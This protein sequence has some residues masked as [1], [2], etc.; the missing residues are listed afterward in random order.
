M[1]PVQP[2]QLAPPQ[3]MP[4][5]QQVVRMPRE[6]PIA[7]HDAQNQNITLSS[8]MP[9]ANR[10][11]IFAS[12]NINQRNILCMIDTGSPINLISRT[13]LH[14]LPFK[15]TIEPSDIVAH[16]ANA[17]PMSLSGKVKLEFNINDTIHYLNFYIV[18]EVTTGVLLG[19]NWLI[20]T[21][22]VLDLK[23]KVL[24]GAHG[25]KIPLELRYFENSHVRKVSLPEDV[26]IPPH[27]ELI[28]PGT[29]QTPLPTEGLL[30]PEN[31]VEERGLLMARVI[32]SP[33]ASHVPVQIINPGSTPVKLYK[34]TNVG[35]LHEIEPDYVDCPV[36]MTIPDNELPNN[37]VN[38]GELLPEQSQK[39]ER[40]LNQYSDLFSNGA[41]DLGKTDIVEHK[42]ETG[43]SLPIKQLP[44]RLPIS[45]R[46]VVDNQIKDMLEAGVITESDSPWSSPIVLAKKKSGDWRFCVDFRRLN[47]VT[48]KDAYSLP[49]IEDMMDD[50][51]GQQYFS[52]L[53]LASGYWQV[54]VE[55]QSKPKTAFSIPSG[56]HYQFESMPF[57]L[58]NAV[59]T[60]QRLMSQLLKGDIG[61]R[62]R[63]YINDILIYGKDF[64]EHLKA[65]EEVFKIFKQ[66]GLKLKGEKCFIAA[67]SVNYLGFVISKNGIEVDPAKVQAI[68]TLPPP[69]NVHELRRFIGMIGYDRKHIPNASALLTPLNK[70]LQKDIKWQWT[71]DCQISFDR[72]K[73]TLTL[74][75]IL[76]YPDFNRDFIVYCDASD[77]GIGA[78]LQQIQDD[79]TEKV[80]AYA[81]KCFSR[82]ESNWSNTEKEA[83]AVVWSLDHFHP[84]IYGRKVTVHTDHKALQ[85][86]RK[87]KSPTGKLAR[88][89]L[90]LEEYDYDVI[91]RP[92]SLMQ[93]VDT[94]SRQPTVNSIH[95]TS[96]WSIEELQI[97]QAEDPVVSQVRPWLLMG[98]KPAQVPTND[99]NGLRTLYNIFDR[100]E[101][102][103][104]LIC[105]EWIDDTGVNKYQV[106][107]PV[108]L[109][110]EI[111]ER[112]HID[113][114][115]LGVKKTFSRIQEEFYW[116]CF[117]RQ[118]EIFC[119]SCVTC[120]KNK[121]I[122]NP[123]WAM[124]PIEVV[125][126]PFYMVGMDVIG[127]LKT[128]P[129]GNRYILNIVDYFTK[130]VEAYAI[131]DQKS[132]TVSRCIEDLC[133]R[134][135]VPSIIL[136]DKGS[137]FTSHLFNGVCAQFGI[138]HRTT[139][140]YH[141]Q[142]DRLTERSN[143]TL[144][145]L[146]RMSA[147]KDQNNWDINL[148]SALQAIRITKHASTGISPFQLLY[149]RPPRLPSSVEKQ[150][151]FQDWSYAD[152]ALYLR[153]LRNRLSNLKQVALPSIEQC[154]RKQKKEYDARNR[155]S[156]AQSFE[157]GDFVLL[158]N[159]RARGFDAKFTGP[160]QVIKRFESDYRIRSQNTGK[161]TVVHFNRLKAC[162]LIEKPPFEQQN[163]E[164]SSSEDDSDVREFTFVQPQ[165][166]NEQCDR[167][168]LELPLQR[169]QRQRRAPDYYGNPVPLD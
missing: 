89:I 64:E 66:A 131:P 62:A 9:D 32:V 92:G 5:P 120:Q 26:T 38:I 69:T 109:Q 18:E 48:T 119:K 90:R 87:I 111:I 132:E 104:G 93:H 23:E 149:G 145:S 150:T 99:N 157:P 37:T 118:T 51:A 117:Y 139:T 80:I 8:I 81:S 35:I 138:E 84:Y 4:Q 144:T 151:N 74:P 127:P 44:R 152:S 107:A 154:Q 79:G 55:E 29:I 54:K 12:F 47:D 135:G 160:Y 113:V 162:D 30:E 58:S 6:T 77:S 17:S 67:Q 105:I 43:D 72:L 122:P 91:H 24:K 28:T 20:E 53:D 86:L 126:V 76:C 164:N 68:S 168:H 128:T 85:W 116:P 100:L 167:E 148:F 98:K 71:T 163:E 78:T 146:L 161:E 57:G 65:L 49:R 141:P 121:V 22:A 158:R 165:Q 115:H 61:K 31:K 42:I 103:D 83:Y 95:V 25:V 15:G 14:S 52:T 36:N 101:L 60:F 3:W 45:L 112:S 147:D 82:V 106:V 88:W 10:N 13:V 140:A 2:Q 169:S 153:E 56:G 156:R 96:S 129:R 166:D 11:M 39:V 97:A 63:A 41:L 136:T 142:C 102:R 19:L 94:L 110:L 33:V 133:S 125:P 137:N 75:P 114:G 27:H 16:A 124:K 134:H 7:Q 73:E 40:L 70:L 50:L 1:P 59:A 155:S 130:Y 123:R 21:E 34:G 159:N 143:A 46:S 108:S